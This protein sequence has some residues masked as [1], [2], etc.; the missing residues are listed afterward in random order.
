MAPQHLAFMV[1]IC[2]LWGLNVVISKIGLGQFDPFLFTFLRFAALGL[3][4]LPFLRLHEGR[5]GTVLAIAVLGGALHFGLMFSGLMIADA[6][7]VG[8]LTQ[9]N[10]PFLTLLSIAFLGES[11]GW[12]RWAGIGLAFAG[13]M[14]IG[15]D[16]AVFDDLTGVVLVMAAAVVIAGAM[17]LMRRLRGVSPFEMQAWVAVVSAPTLGL[18]SLLF[19]TGQWDAVRTADA[20]DWA[21]VAFTVIGA[22]LIGHGG[23]YYLLQ[24]YEASLTGPLTLL[25]PVFSVI[26]A[27]LLLGDPVTGR[28]LMGG[29]LTLLGVLIIA[30]RQGARA[31]A[32]EPGGETR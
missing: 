28:L 26:F 14:V 2:L 8:I 31:S 1:L 22:S 11:V 32:V 4:L 12:R 18:T 5:M 19:E 23:I 29:A 9:L 7:V 10:V 20:G 3:L 21:T 27:V 6:S 16:P 13:V 25:S 17:I 30:L 24:R 15:F